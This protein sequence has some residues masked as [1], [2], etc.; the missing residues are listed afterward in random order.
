MQTNFLI[1][2]NIVILIIGIIV[3]IRYNKVR[4]EK[5][6]ELLIDKI[7]LENLNV[8][9][10]FSKDALAVYISVLSETNQWTLTQHTLSKNGTDLQIWAANTVESRRFYN[11]KNTN[12]AQKELEEKNQKL[13]YYD[14]VLFDKIIQSYKKRQDQLVTKFFL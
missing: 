13:T 2:L 8:I 12:E 4:R 5:F 1:I 9:D 11:N 3:I 7:N 6:L 10:C 14:K